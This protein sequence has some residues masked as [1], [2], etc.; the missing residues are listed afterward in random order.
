MSR[1]FQSLYYEIIED[2]GNGY[3][4]LEYDREPYGSWVIGLS[5]C[6]E[7]VVIYGENESHSIRYEM[8][9]IAFVNMSYDELE[10]FI[11]QIIYYNAEPLES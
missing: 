11:N 5:L 3:T 4:H 6:D 2:V 7:W 1:T 9:T 10:K 8:E